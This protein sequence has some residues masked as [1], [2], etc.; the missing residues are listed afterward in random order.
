VRKNNTLSLG[1]YGDFKN[2]LL[3]GV[4]VSILMVLVSLSAVGTADNEKDVGP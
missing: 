1:V 3:K 2:L 4:K